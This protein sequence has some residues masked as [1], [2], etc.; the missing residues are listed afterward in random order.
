MEDVR[1]VIKLLIDQG[2]DSKK[3]ERA[4]FQECVIAFEASVELMNP[5]FEIARV[6]NI[7]T[8]LLRQEYQSCQELLECAKSSCRNI[9]HFVDTVLPLHEKNAGGEEKTANGEQQ[10]LQVADAEEF[11]RVLESGEDPESLDH[12]FDFEIDQHTL[13]LYDELDSILAEQEREKFGSRSMRVLLAKDFNR[14]LMNLYKVE[15]MWRV[16]RMAF[17]EVKTGN[18]E[19]SFRR[20]AHELRSGLDLVSIAQ[21]LMYFD[22]NPT[23]EEARQIFH[24]SVEL[25]ANG[26]A[27]PESLLV[28]SPTF[29]SRLLEDDSDD[30]GQLLYRSNILKVLSWQNM[31]L[32]SPYARRVKVKAGQTIRLK[33][34]AIVAIQSGSVSATFLDENRKAQSLNLERGDVVGE[35]WAI[36]D[37]GKIISVVA[38]SNSSMVLLSF[39]SFANMFEMRPELYINVCSVFVTIMEETDKDLTAVVGLNAAIG[40]MIRGICDATNK[41]RVREKRKSLNTDDFKELQGQKSVV[42]Q[43]RD[44]AVRKVMDHTRDSCRVE[45]ADSHEKTALIAFSLWKITFKSKLRKRAESIEYERRLILRAGFE[46]IEN[47]WT[48]NLLSYPPLIPKITHRIARISCIAYY[49]LVATPH[50]TL[51]TSTCE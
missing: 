11:V 16:L 28:D 8:G 44:L 20:H 50:L 13:Q 19:A 24:Q 47:S 25:S 22:L 2:L 36:L 23:E 18:F 35:A 6:F 45:W 30:I 40:K 42:Q 46:V 31:H 43:D 5:A 3:P 34:R 29:Q 9:A 4:T 1:K 15:E 12:F 14:C 38:H 21:V 27:T 41:K 7:V 33:E 32:L 39:K 17:V 10:Y 48:G 26:L 49:P 51:S 37:V